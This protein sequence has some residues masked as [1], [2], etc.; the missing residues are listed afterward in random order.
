MIEG[1]P[2]ADWRTWVKVVSGVIASL[3]P[4][5]A[6]LVV[7]IHQMRGVNFLSPSTVFIAGGVL[8]DSRFPQLVTIEDHVYLT[9]GSVVLT[10]FSPTKPMLSLVRGIVTKPVLIKRGAHIGV[11]AVI[12][13]GVVVGE[14][15]IV[16]AGAVVTDDVP[17]RTFAA[18]NPARVVKAVGQIGVKPGSHH[19]GC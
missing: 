5:P 3:L 16:G 14:C 7:W 18:G 13:P 8:I 2:K 19:S 9:R 4:G 12:L 15:S 10:H 11:N 6:R 1:L 17:D